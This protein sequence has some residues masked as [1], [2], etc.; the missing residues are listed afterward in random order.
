MSCLLQSV[1]GVVENMKVITRENSVRVAKYAFE[2][3]RNNGRKKVTTVHKANIM[4]LSD[5]LFLETSREV[6]KE[7]P[8]IKH[9]DMIIDNT[10]MQ[11]VSDPHQFDIINTTNLYGAI[12]SNVLCGLIGGAGLLSGRNYGDHVSKAFSSFLARV[13]HELDT[14]IF[15]VIL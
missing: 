5:G 3:A 6:A 1:H 10:C 14:P 12:V 7:Y 2:F 15:L 13:A 8:E 11:L 9:N 4:K